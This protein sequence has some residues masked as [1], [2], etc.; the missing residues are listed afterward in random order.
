MDI[1]KAFEI[2]QQFEGGSKVINTPGDLGELT[3]Y[4]ISKAAHPSIDIANLTEVEARTIYEKDYWI[5]SGCSKLKPELQYIHFDTSVNMGITAANKILQQ[6]S[7]MASDGIFG[8]ETMTESNGITIGDYLLCRL[9]HYNN[10]IAN[11]A[12]QQVFL[13]GWTNRVVALYQMAKKGELA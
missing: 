11:N 2:L 6:A 8:P 10:I 13:K 1:N 5:A 12:S 9:V 4:G 3:K 7:G